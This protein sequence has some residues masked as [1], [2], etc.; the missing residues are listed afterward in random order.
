VSYLGHID[1]PGRARRRGG[2]DHVAAPTRMTDTSMRPAAPSHRPE[3]DTLR[4]TAILSVLLFHID[5]HWVPNGFLGVDIFFVISGLLI[6]GILAREVDAGDF[7]FSRFYERRARRIVP[8][9]FI[10]ALATSLCAAII[11]LP[12]DL[13]L[14]ARSVPPILTFTGNIHFSRLLDYFSPAATM[15]PLLHIWSLGVEAQFYALFPLVMVPGLK[16]IGRRRMA[17]LLSGLILTTLLFMQIPVRPQEAAVRFFLLPFRV[18][19]FCAGAVIALL[20]PYQASRPQWPKTLSTLGFAMIAGGLFGII[21]P[22]ISARLLTLMGTTLVAFACGDPRMLTFRR[23]LSPAPVR[24]LSQ[25]SYSLYLWHW[26]VVVFS[27]Y[28]LIDPPGFAAKAFM[29]ATSLLLGFASWRWIE[30]P[31]RDQ[32]FPT[33]AFLVLVGCSAALAAGLSVAALQG[34]GWPARFSPRIQRISA[35]IGTHY[36]CDPP[37]SRPAA[38][39]ILC[40]M[41]LGSGNLDDADVV[42]LGNSHAQMYAPLVDEIL[43]RKRLK[44]LLVAS[45]GCLP[46][47]NVNIE[48]ECFGSAEQQI[49]IVERL[50]RAR[51]VIIATRWNPSDGNVRDFGG[52]VP[53]GGSSR[54]FLAGLDQTIRRLESTGKTAL[55]V[56]P[57]AV[58]S[59][60]LASRWARAEAF[61]RPVDIV[62][63]RPQAAYDATYRDLFR[64]FASNKDQLIRIDAVQCARSICAYEFQGEPLFSDG[65]HFARAA[66]HRFK[67]LFERAILKTIGAAKP[68]SAGRLPLAA[69]GR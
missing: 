11:M 58:P 33:G 64:H 59:V 15:A 38:N 34:Q 41:G 28:W 51:L 2:L 16:L 55:V 66:L 26:P 31:T 53:P 40:R 3:M 43:T 10:L 60:E 29:A 39:V 17:L 9:L 65:N 22:I 36:H 24:L 23:R 8:A 61:G 56:A 46:T 50:R 14:V 37:D 1:V 69:S 52:R 5:P 18:W 54:S 13:R 68:N 7:S 27:T 12:S 44:G 4:T 42:L 47:T 63:G 30:R 20:P 21:D 35:V 6:T 48:T 49:E 57:A 67:P 62:L 25:I 32:S 45:D 19:E